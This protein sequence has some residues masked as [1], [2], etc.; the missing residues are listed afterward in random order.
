MT[1]RGL[2]RLREPVAPHPEGVPVLVFAGEHTGAGLETLNSYLLDAGPLL[3]ALSS[4]PPPGELAAE[5]RLAEPR[6]PNAR[7][8]VVRGGERAIPLRRSFS[9]LRG[10]HATHPS[11]TCRIPIQSCTDRESIAE[12]ARRSDGCGAIAFVQGGGRSYRWTGEDEAPSLFGGDP[13]WVEVGRPTP[14]LHLPVID[15]H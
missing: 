3:Y 12:V 7:A 11:G 1:E 8:L 6:S 15:L 9:A 5:R 14:T 10:L 13:G 4:D 2:E